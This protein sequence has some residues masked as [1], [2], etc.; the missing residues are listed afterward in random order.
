MTNTNGQK[1]YD[2]SVIK[3]FTGTMVVERIDKRVQEQS[4]LSDWARAGFHV[5][6]S[7]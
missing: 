5:Q 2:K 4:S 7:H 6:M 3:Q 1:T